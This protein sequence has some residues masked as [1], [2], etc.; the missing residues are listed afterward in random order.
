MPVDHR[1]TGNVNRCKLVKHVTLTM[2]LRGRNSLFQSC[3]KDHAINTTAGVI[4]VGY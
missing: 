3:I 1:G 4:I 2:V